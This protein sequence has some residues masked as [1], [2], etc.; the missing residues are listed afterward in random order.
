M[1]SSVDVA[2]GAFCWVTL[3]TKNPS[4]AKEFYGE[5]FGWRSIQ[6][7]AFGLFLQDGQPVGSFVDQTAD[8]R[9]KDQPPNWLPF[10]RVTSLEPTLRK[11][12][13]LGGR[14]WFPPFSVPQARVALFKGV[15]REILGLWEPL[16][17]DSRFG[18]IKPGV[19]S[20][21]ELATPD[22]DRAKDFYGVLFGWRFNIEGSY[23][24]LTHGAHSLGGVV[25]LEG[26]WEDHA[27]LAAIGQAPEEKWEVPPHWMV[28]FA[29]R[30]LDAIVRKA[31]ALGA[32]IVTRQD[33]LH[34][35]GQFA[36]IRDPQSTYFSVFARL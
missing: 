9:A 27:F 3:S 21:F 4:G 15:T 28:Y 34:T 18:L 22:P 7:G 13:E 24:I 33:T 12:E 17:E 26:D 30:D 31:E 5:L 32:R 35:F 8:P 1:Y 6:Q 14:V 10:V 20:W 19:V 11:A 29:V 23:S 16:D 36:V 2:P 25:K